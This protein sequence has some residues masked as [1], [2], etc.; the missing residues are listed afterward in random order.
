MDLLASC[1][2]AHSVCCMR[3]LYAYSFSPHLYFMILLIARNGPILFHLLEHLN[4][5]MLHHIN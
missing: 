3:L 4:R 5:G 1:L 2:I